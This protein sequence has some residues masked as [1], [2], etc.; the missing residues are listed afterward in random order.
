MDSIFLQDIPSN[1]KDLISDYFGKISSDLYSVKESK[2][3]DRLIVSQYGDK[4]KRYLDIIK[5]EIYDRVF[6]YIMKKT[7]KIYKEG[8]YEEVL[9]FLKNLNSKKYFYLFIRRFLGVIIKNLNFD[10]FVLAGEDESYAE[11]LERIYY[12]NSE[13]QE[14]ED[15]YESKGN[16][17]EA[18]TKAD[19]VNIKEPVKETDSVISY[20]YE[21]IQSVCKYK[22]DVYY[23]IVSNSK[24]FAFVISFSEVVNMSFSDKIRYILDKYSDFVFDNLSSFDE[25]ILKIKSLLNLAY[26]IEMYNICLT[27]NVKKVKKMNMK[28]VNEEVYENFIKSSSDV[29][30][31]INMYLDAAGNVYN[32]E[33][34]DNIKIMILQL[35]YFLIVTDA[36]LI[37]NNVNT[38][39]NDF[40]RYGL[41]HGC[42]DEKYKDIKNKPFF[43]VE[44]NNDGCRIV[45]FSISLSILTT[46]MAK[47]RAFLHYSLKNKDVA[48]NIHIDY[49]MRDKSDYRK[50][51][52]NMLLFYI[53][54]NLD[55]LK[56]KTGAKHYNSQETVRNSYNLTYKSTIFEILRRY[57]SS[58]KAD[59]FYFVD[60]HVVSSMPVLDF[61]KIKVKSKSKSKSKSKN[62]KTKTVSS[63]RRRSMLSVSN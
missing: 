1:V 58:N 56:D 24:D 9:E 55:V 30:L 42:L 61:R 14:E 22:I 5:E 39:L 16:E 54:N 63:K 48:D 52:E 47:F 59:V 43:I 23:Q 44:L 28:N 40:I 35:I 10:F 50:M 17:K 31:L 19:K 33:Y 45:D 36:Y 49:K 62:K 27:T 7:L 57:K 2:K 32:S 20:Y 6:D 38:F 12:L 51:F 26:N 34:N 53:Y 13:L 25:Y 11:A 41:T 18:L 21:Q 29:I 46:I 4:V 8:G 15:Y 37:F 60:N 3:T